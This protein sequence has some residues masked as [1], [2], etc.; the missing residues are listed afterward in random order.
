MELGALFTH[1]SYLMHQREYARLIGA[2]Q[3]LLPRNTSPLRDTLFSLTVAMGHLAL[4]HRAQPRSWRS[5]PPGEG[6]PTGW[7]SPS[8]LIPG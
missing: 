2:A 3:A 4:G 5:S 6:C 1:L 7:C 8:P